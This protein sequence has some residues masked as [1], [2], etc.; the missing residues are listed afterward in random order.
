MFGLKM[1]EAVQILELN[2]ITQGVGKRA[3]SAMMMDI[4][5]LGLTPEKE[6]FC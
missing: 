2:T 4:M 5:K 3:A 6:M 1:E